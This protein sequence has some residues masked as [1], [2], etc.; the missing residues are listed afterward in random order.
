MVEMM[1][2]L[3]IFGIGI[4]ALAQSMPGGIRERDRARRMSVATNLA[5]EQVERLRSLPWAHANLQAGSHTDADNPVDGSYNRTWVVADD[6]PMPGM[7]RVTVRVSFPT[8][9][10]DSQAVFT[11]QITR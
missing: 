11:T 5:Q 4:V 8:A 3:L 1:V 9:S 6:T 2:A 10:A 7:K